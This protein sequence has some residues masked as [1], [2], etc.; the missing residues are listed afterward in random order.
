M[1]VAKHIMN[2]SVL[3]VLEKKTRLVVL[4]AHLHFLSK[5]DRVIVMDQGRIAAIGEHTE[6]IRQFPHLIPMEEMDDECD[7]QSHSNEA[8]LLASTLQRT[9]SQRERDIAEEH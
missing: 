6:V 1:H 4:N 7:D 2:F 8:K 3:S 5:F 9:T